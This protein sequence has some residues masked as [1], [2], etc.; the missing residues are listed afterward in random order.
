MEKNND[1]ITLSKE[2]LLEII[3][4]RSNRCVG[5]TM[6][7]IENISDPVTLKKVLKD[8]IHEEIRDLGDLL[9]VGH[10]VFYS[11]YKDDAK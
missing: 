1:F 4:M 7:L 10:K 6:K 5:K 8:L 2:D 11:N 9:I 3:K